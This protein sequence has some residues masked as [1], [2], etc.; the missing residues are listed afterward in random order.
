MNLPGQPDSTRAVVAR[1]AALILAGLAVQ[2]TLSY[3]YRILLARSG[4]LE[5]FGVLFLGIS[6]VMVAGSLAGLGLD[7]GVARFVPFYL[8]RGEQERARGVL[9][10]ALLASLGAGLA[11]CL[12]VGLAGPPLAAGLLGNQPLAEVLPVCAVSLLFFI[13][14]RVLV[15]AVVAF[16]RIGYRVSV[17]QVLSPLVRLLLTFLLLALGLGVKGALWAFAA[18]EAVAALALLYLLERKVF[19]VF[20]A[21]GATRAAAFDRR[22]FLAY[23][24]PLFLVGIIDLVLNY[25]DAYM[26]AYF[27][28]NTRVGIYGAAVTLVSL[29]ALGSELLNPMFLSLITG[30]FARG[31]LE[32]VVAT[33]NGNNRWYWL[34]ALPLAMLLA[35]FAAEGLVLLFGP[36]YAAGAGT[37]AI[38]TV[39]R[40][41]YYLATTGAFVLSM[42]GLARYILA[43]NLGTA[44]LNILLNWLLI[45][46]LGMFGAALATTISLSLQSLLFIVG[47]LWRHRGQGMRVFYPRVLLAGLL[48]LPPV[49]LLDRALALPPL[50]RVALGGSLYLG[51]YLAGL[52]LL[53]AFTAEDRRIWAALRSRFMPI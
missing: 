24:L 41:G 19:P 5:E 6:T 18:G 15:K 16:Q 9:R 26:G 36:E 8:G 12:L 21:S 27:L 7:L 32:G 13:P 4:G 39:G 33:F 1:G 3:A 17:S 46:R 10:Y 44:L 40:F 51:L 42:H 47:A 35:L 52:L 14:G 11:G 23:S 25:T 30:D 31:N 49:W 34:I 48:A 20:T 37:L 45:P 50:A 38:L 2:R 22:V 53:G 43:V 29:V 28:D